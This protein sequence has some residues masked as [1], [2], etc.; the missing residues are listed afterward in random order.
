MRFEKR[1]GLYLL[2]FETPIESNK[3]GIIMTINTV[4]DI[5]CKTIQVLIMMLSSKRESF[6]RNKLFT[7]AV[8]S[9]IARSWNFYYI[10]GYI[11]IYTFVY[12]KYYTR[13]I[14]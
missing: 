7:E 9:L 5:A 3:R 6:Y 13:Y 4:N 2:S 14:F 1:D 11:R 12:E 10:Y 8:G